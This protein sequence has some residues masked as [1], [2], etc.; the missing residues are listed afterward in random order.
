MLDSRSAPAAPLEGNS[1]PGDTRLSVPRTI[2]GFVLRSSGWRQLALLAL[3]TAV[4]VLTALPLEIQR[5]LVNEAV[6]GG[7]IRL[8]VGLALAYAGVA[9]AE[10]AIKLFLNIYRSWISE[11]A[12]LQ[13]RQWFYRLVNRLPLHRKI[14]DV[15]GIE[16]S[17]ILSEA[18]PVGSV[19][20][21]A[22]SEPVMQ[23]G[24]LISLFGY[25]ALLQPWLALMSLTIFA[26]QM[27]FVPIMQGAINRN[28]SRR[29]QTLR[30]VSI[31]IVADPPEVAGQAD[32]QRSR[33]VRVFDL[34][35]RIY[36]IKFSMNFLMNITNHLG[37]A[38]VLAVGGWLAV[39]GEI[40]I[41][42]VVA[43][44]SGIAKV[45]EPWG[46]IV[47]WYRDMAVAQVKYRLIVDAVESFEGSS[48]V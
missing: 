21:T 36:R 43:F 22:L 46:E 17:V 32:Q 24:L 20:G 13:L 37:V 41:G 2:L 3:S 19:V 4:F 16:I 11:R 7:H 9:L 15:E 35:M 30:E 33:I 42:T 27:V 28:A 29:I 34:N 47:N 40:E 23:G 5:R 1:G 39:K 14:A 45:N 6:G 44:I 31:A 38:A 12:V 26:V 18:E 48:P 10:G 25:M 8:V